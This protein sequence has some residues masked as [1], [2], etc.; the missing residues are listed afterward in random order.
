MSTDQ[1]VNTGLAALT[2]L[3]HKLASGDL[4]DLTVVAARTQSAKEIVWIRSP[5][6]MLRLLTALSENL[7]FESEQNDL[8]TGLTALAD[9]E[10]EGL[11]TTLNQLHQQ[12][13]AEAT[14]RRS[15]SY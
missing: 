5:A 10:V 14:R 4:A 3:G 8:A 2:E 1:D 9:H 12:T 6:E 11:T 13:N 7:V 15:S